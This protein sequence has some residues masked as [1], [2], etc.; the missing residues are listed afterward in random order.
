MNIVVIVLDSLRADHL[1]CYGSKV[2]TPS[3]NEL[4]ADATVFENAYAENLP[5]L[6]CRAAWWTGRHLFTKRGWQPFEH[7]DTL[8][9]EVL[10]VHGFT[11]ALVTDTYHM[12]KRGF[13]C[14]RGFDT[15]CFI[16]G[17]EYDPWIVE[18]SI[19]VDLAKCH[20]LRGD[21]SDKIWKPR[22]AQY[23]R[24]ASTFNTEEDH[25]VARVMM[26]AIEWLVNVSAKQKDNLFLW[27]DSFSPHE[28]WDP[29]QPYRGM[30]DPDYTG[31]ELIDPVPGPVQGYMTEDEV[32]HTKALYA[33][34]VTLVDKWV[35]VLLGALKRLGLFENSLI[36]VTSDHGEP[37]GEHGFI[38][39]ARPECYEELAH[40]PWIVRHP[41]GLG[42][43]RRIPAFVQPTDLMPTILHALGFDQQEV[44]VNWSAWENEPER[45]DMTGASLIPLLSGEQERIRDFAVSAFHENQWSIRT[46]EWSYLLPLDKDRSPELYDRTSDRGETHDVAEENPGVVADL[47]SRLRDFAHSVDSP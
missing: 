22:F 18:K 34:V 3:I 37:F 27:V 23:L 28:P 33:G 17:Q 26:R 39:K 41:A 43:G 13:N 31:Q 10:S 11:S 45:L 6:P 24:N 38:R 15:T 21:E 9:A 14:G 20:R 2:A 7:S 46:D 47:E 44:L 36:M 8:L 19:G 4:A 40:I 42:K 12:H 5:T 1:G 32:N 35:G 29:P 30:Y 16:R 25:F